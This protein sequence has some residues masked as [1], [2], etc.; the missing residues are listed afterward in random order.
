MTMDIY[1]PLT[2]VIMATSIMLPLRATAETV[3][4]SPDEDWAALLSSLSPGDVAQLEAGRYVGGGTVSVSGTP[5]EPIVIRGHG[6]RE[7]IFDGQSGGRAVR[8]EDSR[9]VI[10]E[11]VQITNPS[12]YGWDLDGRREDFSFSSGDARDRLAEGMSLSGCE[13]VT[14][15]HCRFADIATR[16]II[17]SE[18][19]HLTIEENIFLRVGDDTASGDI[20]AG[21]G[22]SRHHITGNLFAGN[23]DGVVHHYAGAGH[24]IERNLFVFHRFENNLDIK[25]H[26][27]RSDED[28][29]SLVTHNVFYAHHAHYSGIE[30]QDST[31]NIRVYFNVIHG[32]ESYGLQIRGR[33]DLLEHIEII[34]N[35]FDAMGDEVGIN[36]RV[37]SADPG[38]VEDVWI[39]HNIFSDFSEHAINLRHGRD[40]HIFNNIFSRCDP[41]ITVTGVTGA[42]NLYHDTEPW[43]EDEAPI[44]GEP[45]YLEEPVGPLAAGSPGS[46]E[47]TI[48]PDHDFGEDVGLPA[49]A[50]G[51]VGLEVSIV[52]DLLDVFTFE[53]VEEAMAQGGLEVPDVPEPPEDAGV[54]EPDAD[55][56]EPDGSLGEDDGDADLEVEPS[57][58]TGA[59]GGDADAGTTPRVGESDRGCSCTTVGGTWLRPSLP[60][61]LLVILLGLRRRLR[62]S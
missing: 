55:L 5:D 34:G 49:E 32:G 29:W 14:I 31:D 26:R 21:S 54:G 62:V 3:N 39:L 46:G 60:F 37:Q 52:S 43:E 57:L 19:H 22:S 24:L 11:N 13:R 20:G 36:V 10:I 6:L 4:V 8:F 40:H 25:F 15:A 2:V 12:P 28:P 44:V 17:I 35:W 61:T 58:E 16:G 38:D 7:S 18:S 47:A 30:I 1:R 50:A 23:V 9:D 53:E 56:G 42:T 45:V 51:L 27:Q 48:L 41:N 59:E 33:S